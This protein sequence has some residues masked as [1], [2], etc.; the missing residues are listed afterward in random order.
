MRLFKIAQ[1]H[2]IAAARWNITD[3][4]QY[5]CFDDSFR[6]NESTLRASLSLFALAARLP[7]RFAM[8]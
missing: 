1:F 6:P 4:G 2:R 3:H 8:T 5:N 7:G